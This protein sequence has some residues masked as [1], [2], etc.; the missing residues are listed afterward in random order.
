MKEPIA[1]TT[2]MLPPP[3]RILRLQ[4][5]FTHHS[6]PF[7][8]P[9]GNDAE[10]CFLNLT[11]LQFRPY[12]TGLGPYPSPANVLKTLHQLGSPILPTL[13]INHHGT[14]NVHSSPGPHTTACLL[15]AC[16]IGAKL[17]IGQLHHTGDCE[18]FEIPIQL[19]RDQDKLHALVDTGATGYGFIDGNFA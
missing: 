13:V 15:L 4:C 5:R 19:S 17:K 14:A 1:E 3:R 10:W 2:T 8:Q 18:P 9:T 12:L 7:G 6:A 16:R 11:T